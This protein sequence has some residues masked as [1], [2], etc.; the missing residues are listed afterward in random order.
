VPAL[1][2]LSAAAQA[3]LCALTNLRHL[4]AKL[5]LT[6]DL[7]TTLQ[8][9][10]ALTQLQLVSCRRADD[11]SALN[12]MVAMS[13]MGWR[14]AV[15]PEKTMA[16]DF[17]VQ[18]RWLPSP[19]R[20][21]MVPTRH[22]AATTMKVAICVVGPACERCS[23][24]SGTEGLRGP[25]ILFPSKSRLKSDEALHN[26]QFCDPDRC[27]QITH[28]SY[29][30]P[31][32]AATALRR[33]GRRGPGCGP[34]PHALPAGIRIPLQLSLVPTTAAGCCQCDVTHVGQA[35]QLAKHCVMEAA[36]QPCSDACHQDLEVEFDANLRGP[37]LEVLP[38]YCPSLKALRLKSLVLLIDYEYFLPTL[39][40]LK[41]SCAG[42]HGSCT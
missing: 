15:Y 16:C 34:V 4:E 31:Q 32:T 8:P 40:Q 39:K 24:P 17:A 22:A 9:L 20:R 1:Q 11:Q 21:M 7:L 41:V 14:A 36:S 13:I 28:C 27:F 6:P 10:H 30:P 37:G 19:H 5:P 42:V 35:A 33:C 25:H 23:C 26:M 29:V 38:R 18:K 3:C 2:K 12:H